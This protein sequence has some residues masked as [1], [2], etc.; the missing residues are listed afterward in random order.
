MA[1]P[2]VSSPQRSA[3]PDSASTDATRHLCAGVFLDRHF[4]D[5]VIRKVC[6]DARRWVA[7]SYGFDLVPVVRHAWRARVVEAGQQV[8]LLLV[9]AFGWVWNA[10]AALTACCVIALAYLLPWVLRTA[11]GVF[12]GKGKDLASRALNRSDRGSDSKLG[13]RARLLT[14]GTAACVFLV[15]LPLVVA[16]IQKVPLLDLGQPAAELL[17]VAA[18]IA[19]VSGAAR[20][21]EL[22]RLHAAASL[23]PASLTHRET[24]IDS[25]QSNIYVIYRRQ[26]PEEPALEE[27]LFP[28][29]PDVSDVPAFFVGSGEMLHRWLPPLVIRLLKSG[30][31][32]VAE[33]E[34]DSAPFEAHALVLHLRQAVERLRDDPDPMMRLT[35]L[36]VADRLYVA[37]PDVADS[38]GFR[39]RPSQEELDELIDDPLGMVS[40]F[41]EICVT[42]SGELVTTVFLRV[43]VKGGSLTLDFAA[44]ALTRT[45]DAYHLLDAFAETGKG[46]VVRSAFRALRDAPAEIG[47]SWR[48]AELPVLF[49][50]ATRASTDVTLIPHRGSGIAARLSIREEKSTPWD[51]AQ[52]DEPHFLAHIKIIETCLLNA[53]EDFLNVHHVDVSQ[54]STRASTIINANVL[55][56]GRMNID[57]SAFGKNAQVNNDAS[58]NNSGNRPTP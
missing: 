36:E 50:R 49:A 30:S 15:V 35:G 16:A 38:Q 21:L 57:R 44:S 43:S 58:R 5:L 24:V 48:L 31:G 45:P 13:E 11:P 39:T 2:Q 4:L 10:S 20:Q 25:Q 14:L 22:N 42:T 7:P 6:N 51:K 18:G 32:S 26:K 12:R 9:L 41:L 46:A 40:H 23:R 52:H 3:S 19:V 8:G 56:M 37:E 53:T 1:Q 34:Y 27:R 54:F 29:F 55:N 28:D 47:R 17:L 33:R